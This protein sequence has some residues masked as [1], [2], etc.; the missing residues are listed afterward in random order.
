MLPVGRPREDRLFFCLI[1][2]MICY[3]MLGI[4]GQA[5]GCVYVNTVNRKREAA[6]RLRQ[7]Y[8]P[9]Y[10]TEEPGRPQF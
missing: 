1:S 2:P 9:C 3:S 8:C 5:L 6:V 4:E 7:L 10:D